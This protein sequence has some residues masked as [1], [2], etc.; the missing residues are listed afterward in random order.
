MLY[1]IKHNLSIY[2]SKIF[3]SKITDKIV[4]YFYLFYFDIP[5][6]ANAPQLPVLHWCSLFLLIYVN[7]FFLY[8]FSIYKTL[9]HMT[10]RAIYI[11]LFLP[12]EGISILLVIN[13]KICIMWCCTRSTLHIQKKKKKKNVI[14]RV[15][16]SGSLNE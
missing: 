14:I 8:S 11:F 10:M 16:T 15:V 3:I 13:N 4:I 6:N 5:L 9:N 2:P 7:K 12:P 1:C